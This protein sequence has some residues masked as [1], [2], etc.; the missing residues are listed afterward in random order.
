MRMKNGDGILNSTL[1]VTKGV[2]CYCAPSLQAAGATPTHATESVSQKSL[3]N[4]EKHRP[5]NTSNVQQ[6]QVTTAQFGDTAFAY[7]KLSQFGLM[8]VN[9]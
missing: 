1:V 9:K 3:R 7:T 8:Q 4:D 2:L 5:H 6:Q